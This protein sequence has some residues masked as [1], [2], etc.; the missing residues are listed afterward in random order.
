M[1][2]DS[3]TSKDVSNWQATQ[4]QAFKV[5]FSPG[6][7]LKRNIACKALIG[8]FSQWHNH[9]HS[10]QR[11]VARTMVEHRPQPLRCCNLENPAQHRLL[12]RQLQAC[13]EDSFHPPPDEYQLIHT[14]IF[15]HL[16]ISGDKSEFSGVLYA[17]KSEPNF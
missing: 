11:A 10:Q 8:I 9:P 17:N 2:S 7:N 15:S 5:H 4:N 13:R 6:G 3:V 14:G 16:N 1:N 12:V